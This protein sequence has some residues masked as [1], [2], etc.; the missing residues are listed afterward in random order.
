MTLNP[1]DPTNLLLGGLGGLFNLFGQ[2][3][4]RQLQQNQSQLSAAQ[5]EEQRG[6]TMASSIAQF[7][8][9]QQGLQN[10]QAMQGLAATQMDP[11]AQAKALNN[12]QIKAQFAQG[13]T[14]GQG[15]QGKFSTPAFSPQNL[16]SAQ[17]QFGNYQAAASPNVPITNNPSAE[18]FRQQYQGQQ[19]SLAAQIQQWLQQIGQY[20]PAGNIGGLYPTMNASTMPGP[21]GGQRTGFTGG[22]GSRAGLFS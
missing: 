1:L 4:E 22:G 6:D 8:Q 20:R 12:A 21:G 3:S 18:Q 11:Y 19:Q 16:T 17:Q 10:T 15:F 14:P 5:G 9:G 7:L 2:N 13:Y